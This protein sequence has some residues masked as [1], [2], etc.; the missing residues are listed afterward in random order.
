MD[1]K[2]IDTNVFIEVFTR[3]GKKSD[4]SKKLV[5][6]DSNL[7]TNLL[8]ISEVIWVLNSIYEMKKDLVIDCLKKILTSNVEIEKKKIIINAVNFY[9]KNN[10]DW[11]DCLNMFLLKNEDI[12]TVYSYDRGLN[13]FNWIKRIEP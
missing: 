11:T 8:V 3:F 9:G 4:D 12:T 13:K 1:S 2:F 5:E 6:S 7:C 10:V